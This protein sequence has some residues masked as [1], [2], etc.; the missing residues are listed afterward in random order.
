MSATTPRERLRASLQRNAERIE[1]EW[2]PRMRS[3]ISTAH[4]FD[5]ARVSRLET[6]GRH[7]SVHSDESIPDHGAL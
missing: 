6:T 2:T 4:V 7:A 3:A 1:R 5:V